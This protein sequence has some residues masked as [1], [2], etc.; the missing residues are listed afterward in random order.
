MVKFKGIL[1]PNRLCLDRSQQGK[2][3][4]G[5]ANGHIENKVLGLTKWPNGACVIVVLMSA[6]KGVR[7]NAVVQVS[8]NVPPNLSGSTLYFVTMESLTEVYR[9]FGRNSILYNAISTQ[10]SR[11][12]R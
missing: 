11:R 3:E 4:N 9:S 2:I 1:G 8:V 7:V 10:P 6:N 5:P 12:K